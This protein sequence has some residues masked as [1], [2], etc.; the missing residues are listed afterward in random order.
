MGLGALGA[1]AIVGGT[2]GLA[3]RRRKSGFFSRICL[4][5]YRVEAV[6]L[7]NSYINIC[8]SS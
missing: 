7:E 2:R 1:L 8:V 5:S 6:N 3:V 4:K